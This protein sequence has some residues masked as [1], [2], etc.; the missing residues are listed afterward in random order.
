MATNTKTVL[1]LPFQ[2]VQYIA[3]LYAADY[4][5][6]VQ[7]ARLRILQAA[8]RLGIDR[9]LAENTSTRGPIEHWIHN[10]R[11]ELHDA[12]L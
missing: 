11:I 12:R 2:D 7:L 10:Q 3:K 1:D 4:D 6:V 5:P 9:E 8:Q